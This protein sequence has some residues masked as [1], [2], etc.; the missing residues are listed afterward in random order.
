M[1]QAI[2][3]RVIDARGSPLADFCLADIMKAGV[4]RSY[5]HACARSRR[6][7]G[8]AGF[9]VLSHTFDRPQR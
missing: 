7:A 5:H 9:F 3:S 1:D 8:L 2:A 4:R 6:T